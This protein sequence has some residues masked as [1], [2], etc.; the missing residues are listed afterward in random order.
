MENKLYLVV[1]I[2]KNILPSI[3]LVSE[4]EIQGFMRGSDCCEKHVYEYDYEKIK[5]VLK[6]VETKVVYKTNG[7]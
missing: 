7:N 5:S 3:Y 4:Q 6:E 1:H 2:Y